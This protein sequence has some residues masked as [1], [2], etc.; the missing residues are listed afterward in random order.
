MSPPEALGP[1]D[2]QMVS[3]GRLEQRDDE[4]EP[5]DVVSVE[6]FDLRLSPKMLA[7]LGVTPDMPADEAESRIIAAFRQAAMGIASGLCGICGAR[8]DSDGDCPDECDHNPW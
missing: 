2:V 1:N 6:T 3:T 8:K 5:G 4:I 7:A